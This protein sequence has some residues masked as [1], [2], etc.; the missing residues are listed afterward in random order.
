MSIIRNVYFYGQLLI[1]PIHAIGGTLDL[2][3]TYVSDLVHMHVIV[4]ASM[5]V[6][7]GG[8]GDMSLPLSERWGTEYHLSPPL[9]E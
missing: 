7:G 8:R 3:M 1:D 5:G 9:F 6:A 2:L 4:V